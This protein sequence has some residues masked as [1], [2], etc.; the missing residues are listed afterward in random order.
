[1]ARFVKNASKR[2][3]KA[4]FFF[5]PSSDRGIYACYNFDDQVRL[6]HEE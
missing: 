1:L 3:A 4:G 5:T 6:S 2:R